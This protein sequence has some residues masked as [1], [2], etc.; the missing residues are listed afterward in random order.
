[1]L[2]MNL[3]SS[4]SVSPQGAEGLGR[5]SEELFNGSR[6]LH[7]IV[8]VP[9]EKR[10]LDRDGFFDMIAATWLFGPRVVSFL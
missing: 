9:I 7:E 5:G 3:G 8:H 1:M 2:L 6:G 4:S 10:L